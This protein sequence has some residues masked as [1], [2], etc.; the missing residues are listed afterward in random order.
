MI[1]FVL[2]AGGIIGIAGLA[3][4]LLNIYAYGWYSAREEAVDKLPSFS[5]EAF[6]EIQNRPKPVAVRVNDW[7]EGFHV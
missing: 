4:M 6:H 7:L 2:I 3:R 1:V 5:C